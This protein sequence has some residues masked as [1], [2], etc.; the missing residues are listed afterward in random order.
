MG[1][2]FHRNQPFSRDCL[3]PCVSGEGGCC[4]DLSEHRSAPKGTVSD[5][6]LDMERV[7]VREEVGVEK[8]EERGVFEI[9]RDAQGVMSDG[10]VG[11]P[12]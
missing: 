11:E 7:E 3:N 4:V 9:E 6:V 12:S 10:I 1:S 2:Y 8:E 5:V